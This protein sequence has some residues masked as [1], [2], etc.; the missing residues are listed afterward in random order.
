MYLFNNKK[1]KYS[2]RI[3][4]KTDIHIEVINTFGRTLKSHIG[5]ITK[6][7]KLLI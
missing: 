4:T 1:S 7:K 3:L 5:R 2:E 6:G